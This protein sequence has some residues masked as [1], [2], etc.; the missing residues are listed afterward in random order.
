MCP[1][2]MTQRVL[3]RTARWVDASVGRRNIPNRSRP[4]GPPRVPKGKEK[5]RLAEGRD[6]EEGGAM[7]I[8]SPALPYRRD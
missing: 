6:P 7:K 3:R 8:T 4:P 1:R 5:S 2:P